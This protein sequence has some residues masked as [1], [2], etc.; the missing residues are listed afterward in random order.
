MGL[1]GASEDSILKLIK[2]LPCE[3]AAEEKHLRDA[4]TANVVFGGVAP[5][6]AELQEAKARLAQLRTVYTETN[7]SVQQQIARIKELENK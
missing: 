5:D 2:D 4:A 3:P 6:S 1:A 7:K